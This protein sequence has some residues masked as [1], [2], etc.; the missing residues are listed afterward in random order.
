MMYQAWRRP[1]RKPSMQRR[2]LM[3]ESAEQRPH[4]T[5]TVESKVLVERFQ[6]QVRCWLRRWERISKFRNGEI[7]WK[8]W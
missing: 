6:Y 5:Q 7:G 3:R 8:R 2:M 4:F 1:G